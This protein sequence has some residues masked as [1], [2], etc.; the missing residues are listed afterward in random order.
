MAIKIEAAQRL[1]AMAIKQGDN[2]RGGAQDAKK[3]LTG[4][5]SDFKVI[6]GSNDLVLLKKVNRHRTV[7]YVLGVLSVPLDEF[8][9]N[10]ANEDLFEL[11]RAGLKTI[12]GFIGVDA[13]DNR[14]SQLISIWIAP[15]FQGKGFG[16]GLYKA[17]YDNS[18]KGLQSSLDLGTMSLGTWLSLYRDNPEIHI[19]VGVLRTKAS[20]EDRV[21]ATREEIKIRGLD[22]SYH[23]QDGV[24]SLTDPEGPVFYF[25]WPK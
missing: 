15:A 22:V 10:L 21:K 1:Q 18:K 17:A 23:N 3:L 20:R 9:K 16:K 12:V 11:R 7:Y 19:T 24:Q 2:M 25:V 5:P 6:G 14:P 8:K 13:F 4:E